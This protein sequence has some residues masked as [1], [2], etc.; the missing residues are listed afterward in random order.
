MP[1][2][3]WL[4]LFKLSKTFSGDITICQCVSRLFL[5]DQLIDKRDPGQLQPKL[6]H[7]NYQTFCFSKHSFKNIN[8]IYIYRQVKGERVTK[9]KQKEQSANYKSG[10]VMSIIYLLETGRFPI[11]YKLHSSENQRYDGDQGVTEII[12]SI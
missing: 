10:Y 3:H 9:Q 11:T 1:Y 4:K 8:Y 6:T 2:R 5:F 12:F 7:T